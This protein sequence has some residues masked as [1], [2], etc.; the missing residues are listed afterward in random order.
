MI[1]LCS[2]SYSSEGREGYAPTRWSAF[3]NAGPAFPGAQVAAADRECHSNWQKLA[4]YFPPVAAL[5]LPGGT[6]TSNFSSISLS[7][8]IFNGMQN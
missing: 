7:P 6:M 5:R 2:D 1:L 8:C 4:H 3:R